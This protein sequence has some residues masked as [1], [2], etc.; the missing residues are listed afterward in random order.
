MS[1][2]RQ[3]LLKDKK[4]APYCCECNT[5]ARM[6]FNGKQ[7]VCHKCKRETAFESEFISKVVEFRNS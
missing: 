7:F 5:M 3:N 4:Y 2:V 1:I 6:V